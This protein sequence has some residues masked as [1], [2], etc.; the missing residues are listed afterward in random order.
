MREEILLY[1]LHTILEILLVTK[2][3]NVSGELVVMLL[4]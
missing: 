4:L 2:Q 3:L 1:K